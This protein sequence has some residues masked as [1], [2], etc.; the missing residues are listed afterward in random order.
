MEFREIL[1]SERKK[2]NLS[3][4]K[5][6]ELLSVSRQSISKWENGDSYPEYP[7]LIAL[8]EILNCDLDYLCGRKENN[9]DSEEKITTHNN[10]GKYLIIAIIMLIVGCVIGFFIGGNINNG[11]T[12]NTVV[13]MP[14]TITVKSIKFS[15]ENDYVKLTFVPSVINEDFKYTVSFYGNSG[16][17]EFDVQEI[18][19]A[20]VCVAKLN[21]TGY[22]DVVLYVDNREE[23][24]EIPLVSEFTV[25]EYGFSWTPI[26]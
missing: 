26:E 16:T 24:R 21:N 8:A 15:K 10:K 17:E 12:D 3:Q 25:D 19:G 18:N 20:F 2:N 14:D 22:R 7:K 1:I 4:E 11:N 5:L 6:S 23:K 9:D 13:E